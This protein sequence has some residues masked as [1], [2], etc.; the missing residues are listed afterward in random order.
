MLIGTTGVGSI[1]DVGSGRTWDPAT[2]IGNVERRA[3]VLSSLGV[4]RGT[5][6]A[7]CHGNSASFFA[8]LFAIWRLGSCAICLNPGLSREELDNVLAFMK[9]KATLIAPGGPETTS[10]VTTVICLD[11]ENSDREAIRQQGHI[12]DD[13]LIL[14][15]SGTT[16][17]PKGVVHT[18]RSILARVALNKS[19]IGVKDLSSTLCVLPTH[20]GHG[21]IGNCLTPLLSGNKLVLSPGG[22]LQVAASLGRLIDDHD[23][24]FMSSVP[25]FWKLVIKTAGNP[26][27]SVLKRV[28]IGS[29][30]LSSDLW[31]EVIS[32]SGTRNVANM[33]GITETANW[34]S[35]AS[36]LQ[37]EPADGAIGSIWGGRFA[38]TT[39]GGGLAPS[40]DGE[41]VVQTPSL[42][43]GYY[44]RPDLTEKVIVGGWYFTGDVGH[45]ES[46][47]F[48]YLTGRRK[49][50]I[51][52]AGLKVHPEDI[53][54]LLERHEMVREACAF[55]LPDTISG[56]IV[57]VAVCATAN[58]PLDTETLK[59]WCSE[60]ISREK[61]PTRWFVVDE[62]P[63]TDRGKINRDLVAR[64]CLA[65]ES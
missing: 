60:R 13:A 1:V 20:F 34:I 15:T 11:E 24:T 23:I 30:P 64:H 40:G 21:L 25:A 65:L 51:N 42:M 28:H 54:L 56:E 38:V 43:T 50:E 55:G 49:F 61:V 9:P 48:A 7:I 19:F 5:K 3:A 17:T 52:R 37:R 39:E 8:D 22:Q 63:K 12:D 58:A 18:F 41:I 57:A 31:R 14:L 35:G 32:W 44:E 27:N 53:D 62:I 2:I 47:G 10:D 4:G 45:I 59:T 46:D 33:Y 16:G 29:A 6:V 26:D 36:S